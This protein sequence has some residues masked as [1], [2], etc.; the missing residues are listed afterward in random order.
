LKIRLVALTVA[1]AVAALLP[2]GVA[3]GHTATRAQEPTVLQMPAGRTTCPGGHVCLFRDSNYQGGGVNFQ[4]PGSSS[5][6][7]SFND[8]MSSWANDSGA[9]YCWYS[10]A[11]YRGDRH[12]M[13]PGYRLNVL[14]HENDTASSIRP[15]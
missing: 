13:K 10:D 11:D 2:V 15:C 5:Y 8:Q 4:R 3:T 14:P 12:E 7:G 1:T 6:L 9:L